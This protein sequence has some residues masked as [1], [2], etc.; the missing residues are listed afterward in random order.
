MHAIRVIVVT[1]P[2]IKPHTHKHTNRQDRLQY[3][4]PLS[5]VRSVTMAGIQPVIVCL[6]KIL[7][8][9]T[10]ANIVQSKM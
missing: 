5:L 8:I 4:A 6:W 7:Y 10:S 2:Q 9:Q 1:D 3:T